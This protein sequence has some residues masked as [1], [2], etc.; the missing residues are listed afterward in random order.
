MTIIANSICK[1]VKYTDIA[2][3]EFYMTSRNEK[4]KIKRHAL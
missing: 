2:C 4:V 1:K 3:M